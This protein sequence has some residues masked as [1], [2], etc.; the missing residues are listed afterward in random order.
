MTGL[1]AVSG[2]ITAGRIRIWIWAPSWIHGTDGNPI[3]DLAADISA[4]TLPTNYD[5]ISLY[6]TDGRL[7]DEG[8]VG[9]LWAD[10][11]W[12]VEQV[13]AV[14]N[15]LDQD[16]SLEQAI[17]I[18]LE[19]VDMTSQTERELA[20]M[21]NGVIEHDMAADAADLSLFY[22]GEDDGFDGGDVLFPN[23]YDEIVQSLAE[24]LTIKTGHVVE[25]I[26]YDDTGV[27]ITTSQANFE[28]DRAIVTL[29]LGVLK[30]AAVSFSPPLPGWKQ[31][32]IDRLDMGILNKLY[33]RFESPFWPEDTDL[34]GYIAADKG[35]WAEYLNIFKYTGQPI[36]LAFNAA[37]YGRFLEELADEEIVASA[38]D[39]LRGIF[40]S[41]IPEPT[42]WLITRW[43][44]DPFAGGSYSHIPV[45]ASGE[46][47]DTMAGPVANRLYFAGEATTRRYP[48]TVH[49]AFLS[50]VRE[51]KKITDL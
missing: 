5:S 41:N 39:T 34:L 6:H 22:L 3:T 9:D 17:E 30:A 47:Y 36:L 12:L 19:D 43:G 14:S 28:A 44:S 11:E 50:G 13:E 26:A 29:P 1:E 48:A 18:A 4:E 46:D 8:E 38:M 37:E 23:G 21:I 25:E 33:L 32:A 2:Q 27:N 35:H 40:G 42:D 10:F 24:G 49:G 7:L 31:E 51:A 20:Y 16:V 45:G 15:E